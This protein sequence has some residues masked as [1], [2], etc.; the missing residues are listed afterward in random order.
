[1]SNIVQSKIYAI[2]TQKKNIMKLIL[3]N[4][5]QIN[6][7]YCQFTAGRMVLASLFNYSATYRIALEPAILSGIDLFITLT[8]N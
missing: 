7:A 2:Y 4:N 5:S 6:L 8:V 3:I 1:M